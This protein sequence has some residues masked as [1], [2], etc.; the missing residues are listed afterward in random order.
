MD[1]ENIYECIPQNDLDCYYN[2]KWKELHKISNKKTSLNNFLM[3]QDNIDDEMYKF[4]HNAKMGLNMIQDNLIRLRDSYYSRNDYAEPII[5]LIKIIKNISC[6]NDLAHV[7]HILNNMNIFTLFTINVSPHFKK[8]DIYVLSIGEIPLTLESKELYDKDFHELIENYTNMLMN[9]YNFVKQKWDYDTSNITKFCRN[10]LI[11]EIL[12]SKSILSLEEQVDPHVTHNSILYEKFIEE[13]DT[14]NF[15]KIILSEYIDNYGE[16]NSLH[17]FQ[18]DDIDKILRQ[19]NENNENNEIYIVYENHKSL[20]FIKNFLQKMT[21]NELSMTKDY[22]VYCLVK[23]YGM[24]TSITS[25]LSIISLSSDNDKR[26]FIDLF[27]ETFGYYLQTVYESKYYDI[28]KKNTIYD[29]FTNIKIYC[30]EVFKKTNIFSDITKKE[31]IKKLE[32]LN[33]IIGK[34]DYSINLLELPRLG[35][36]FYENLITLHSFFFRKLISFVGKPINKSYLSLSNDIYSFIINAYYDP[37]SNNIFI[38]TSI[39]ND[40]FFKMNT[41]PLYNYGSLGAII[42]HEIMHCFDN[43]GAQFDY[44]GHLHNWWTSDDYKKFNC[45]ISK[46]KNHYLKFMLNGIKV[47]SSLS[48]SENFAD[49]CGLKLSLRTYIKVYM[50]YTDIGKLSENE[51]EHLKKFFERWAQ[52]LRALENTDMLKY[53]VNYE[54]HLPNIIRINAPFSHMY[55]YYEIFNVKPYHFNYL[56]PEFRTNFLDL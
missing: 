40:I 32:N 3:I 45:E 35:N 29:I 4:I 33:V 47:N 7:I 11:F 37:A 46:V 8:P 2:Y 24:Y 27:Y 39:I 21:Q 19:N 56:E 54:V 6:I 5:E 31:A 42:G 25:S 22:L 14:D 51:K 1:S 34:Q 16:Q 18:E 28:Q 36:N 53:E 15:W 55:E 13:F 52:T 9:I 43:H 48:V 50:P 44:K 12:F 23:K 20:I 30:L 10:I 49:I 38:P 41:G 26:N 17:Y